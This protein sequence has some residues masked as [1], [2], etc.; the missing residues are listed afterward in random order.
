MQ[1]LLSVGRKEVRSIGVSENKV[2]YT[3][4]GGTILGYTRVGG[5]VYC[6]GVLRDESS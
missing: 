5:S 6:V 4:V 2:Y 3:C 1:A